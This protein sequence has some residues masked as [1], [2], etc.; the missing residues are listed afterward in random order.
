M[1]SPNG[2]MTPGEI[3]RTL[4]RIDK[5]VTDLAH[6][7]RD[8]MRDT[9]HKASNALQGVELQK[10]M[11]AHVSEKLNALD[12]SDERQWETINHLREN[13]ASQ[14]AVDS[15]RRW[16][17]GGGSL[18]GLVAIVNLAINISQGS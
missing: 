11:N 2:E 8:E 4:Q 15:Y 17:I 9:R 16:L 14:E 12:G 10:V 1:A 5:T 3:S 6:E 7:L 18:F 13:A